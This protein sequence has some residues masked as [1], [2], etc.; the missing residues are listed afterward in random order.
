MFLCLQQSLVGRVVGWSW[1]L[2]FLTSFL[3]QSQE[4]CVLESRS[5]TEGD[6]VSDCH[7]DSHCLPPVSD[8]AVSCRI[9]RV[10]YARFVAGDERVTTLLTQ[11][12]TVTAR[13]ASRFEKIRYAVAGAQ[14]ALASLVFEPQI[15]RAACL[16]NNHQACAE[17]EL[18]VGHLCQMLVL[19]P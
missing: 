19:G 8:T 2:W 10:C 12:Y 6:T 3:S 13:V 18:L 15:L 5:A 17:N 4:S 1:T 11:C 7:R 14:Q 16:L 9:I